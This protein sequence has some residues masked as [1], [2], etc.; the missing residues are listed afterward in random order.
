MAQKVNSR[1]TE[2]T[3]RA[4]QATADLNAA[5]T[6]DDIKL[7]A[8]LHEARTVEAGFSAYLADLKYCLNK[9]VPDGFCSF[10]LHNVPQ[11]PAARVKAWLVRNKLAV[12]VCERAS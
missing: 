3:E 11:W 4:K 5:C 2:L 8:A 10:R 1:L 9:S 7:V 12:K 6:S